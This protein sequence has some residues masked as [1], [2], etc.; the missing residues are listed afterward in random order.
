MMPQLHLVLIYF[1]TR[2]A[3]QYL[4]I[5]IIINNGSN[6]SSLKAVN[7]SVLLFLSQRHIDVHVYAHTYRYI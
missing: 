6:S 7:T 5:I 1:P 2:N 3:L 4:E